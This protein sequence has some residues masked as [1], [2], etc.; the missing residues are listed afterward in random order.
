[1]LVTTK[2]TDEYFMPLT[3]ETVT[4]NRGIVKGNVISAQIFHAFSVK[5]HLSCTVPPFQ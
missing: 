1:M 4:R 5:L 3:D 2:A